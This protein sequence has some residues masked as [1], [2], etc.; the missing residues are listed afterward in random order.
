MRKR[1]CSLYIVQL[2][3][4]SIFILHTSLGMAQKV[5]QNTPNIIY[6]YADDLGYG[7]LGSYGQQKIKTP[8]LDRLAKEGVRF[9]QHYAGAPVCAPSRAMLMTGKHAGH[10]YI[11][12][13][14]ELGGFRDEDEGGQMPLPEGIFTL[15]KMLKQAG[16][17]T[18][19]SG[20]WGLGMAGTSGDPL[21]HGF[22]YYY[23]LLDQ[24]QA[25]NFYPT[26]LWENSRWDTLKNPVITVHRPIDSATATQKDFDY[27]KGSDYSVD[28]MTD[29]AIGFIDRYKGQRF[30]LYLPYTLPHVSLQV[31]DEALTPYLGKFDEKPYYGQKGYTSQKYPRSAYAAMVSYLDK[32]V[33][34]I[35]AKIEEAGL[36]DNTIIMF[37]SDNGS[38]IEGGA[39]PEF[40]NATGG[41][42]G[43]KRDLYEGGIRVP[44]LARWPGHIKP[45]AVSDHIS[46]QYDLLATLAELCGGQIHGN[47]DGISFLPALIGDKASQKSHEYLYFEFPEKGGQVAIRLGKW[48]GIRTEVKKDRKAAWQLYDLSNDRAETKN[49]ADQQPEIIGRMEEIQKLAHQHAH[50]REWEFIDPKFS[51]K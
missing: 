21:M 22:D 31:P 7:E 40:F 2:L 34:L 23:G 43:T 30:F 9:T 20:K 37:S 49:L 4:T 35:M 15:P 47:T 25:H 11:R 48:K 24:K 42:R 51:E 50:I 38:S 28:K 8:Q 32:Q 13:N 19:M 16:Y 26:H 3:L 29:K 44:F 6:I 5:S 12:G 10:S 17:I 14:Y 33:G 36:D 45:G 27:F 18:G 39:D 41:L 1:S 46:T